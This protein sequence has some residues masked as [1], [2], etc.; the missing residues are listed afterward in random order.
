[1]KCLSESEVGEAAGTAHGAGNVVRLQIWVQGV[2][3][4]VFQCFRYPSVGLANPAT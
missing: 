2:L 3:A 4:N 1:M